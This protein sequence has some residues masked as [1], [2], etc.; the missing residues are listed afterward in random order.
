MPRL[1]TGSA[2]P[3]AAAVPYRHLY[4]RCCR[5]RAGARTKHLWHSRSA[6]FRN[7]VM[8]RALWVAGDADMAGVARHFLDVADQGLPGWSLEFLVPRGPLVARLQDLGAT[9]HS[10]G[11]GP[12]PG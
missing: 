4:E 1:R 2:S 11:F 9:V 12:S 8:R 10:E 6:L 7:S 5:D 3:R